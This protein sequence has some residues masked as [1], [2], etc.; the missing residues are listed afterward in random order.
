MPHFLNSLIEDDIKAQGFQVNV[1]Q[2]DSVTSEYQT[3]HNPPEV[4][5][6]LKLE[7]GGNDDRY[8][9]TASSDIEITYTKEGEDQDYIK[10]FRS[11][12]KSGNYK[13]TDIKSRS[14]IEA[15]NK[16]L[17]VIIDTDEILYQKSVILFKNR[18]P[19]IKFPGTF[20]NDEDVLYLG[21]WNWGG[22][23]EKLP[24]FYKP[25]Y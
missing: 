9:M 20:S 3:I 22:L 18:K 13:Y 1:V 15:G 25:R 23:S 7:K 21:Y 14:R 17:Q 8:Q 16:I 19:Q 4:D 10:Q 11:R 5:D 2:Y 24:L 12:S 6:I